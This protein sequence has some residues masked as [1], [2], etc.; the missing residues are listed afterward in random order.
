MSD[1]IIENDILKATFDRKNGAL[2]GLLSKLSG[3]SIHRRRELGLS[4][5]MLVPLEERRNN[6]IL[7]LKQRAPAVEVDCGGN[8]IVFVWEKLQSEYG[9]QL[10]ITFKGV[11][12]ICDDGLVFTPEILN[13]SDR[14]VEVVS[15]PVVGDVTIPQQ[16]QHLHRKGL[17][18]GQMV[19]AEL[20]PRFEDNC[21]YWG[22]DYPTQQVFTPETP[23]VL[24]DSEKQGL[25]VGY[26]DTTAKCL[27]RYAFLLRPGYGQSDGLSIGTVPQGD[28]IGAEPVC[29]EFAA[30]HL[31]YIAGGDSVEL[32]PI[33]L[34][35]Y[36]GSWEAGADCY[37]KWRKTWF[38]PPQKPA[39]TQEV[40]SWQQIHIN[41]PED[42][43]RCRYKN[44]VQYGRDCA[45]HGVGAIQLTGWTKDGQD[46]GNPSHDVEPRLGSREE[47]RDAI[48]AIEEMGVKVVLFNKYTWA[49]R[50]REQ[51]RA[52]LHRHATIDPYGDMHVFVGYHYQTSTQLS[53]INT[54]RFSV[55]CQC[56]AEWRK[57]AV[58]E[59]K[60][61]I[62]LGASGMLY[63]ECQHHGGVRYCFSS[64]HGHTVPAYLFSGDAD[65]AKEFRRVA[66]ELN[67][68]YLF[69]G[70]ACYDLE[71]EHYC[72]SY[73]RIDSRH[74]P[75][76][77]YVAPQAE[78]MI[79][80]TGY[81]NRNTINQALLYRYI[82]SYEPRN[83]KGRLDE[84]PLTLAYG[85]QVD[86]LRRRYATM[87]W[88]AKYRGT[89]GARITPKDSASIKYS[90]F[91]S[92][93]MSKRAVIVANV[94][95]Q[96][97]MNICVEFDGSLTGSL[98]LV[99]PEEPNLR[100]SDGSVML[101]PLS[102]AVIME[103]P[104]E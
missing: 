19:A 49:D 8:R 26:H 94:D 48:E 63:D 66:N 82:L 92:R 98:F 102:A 56:S 20:Y 88:K 46:G 12:T 40:H 80:I 37:K 81:N 38:T 9:G 34:Q 93:Q 50:S 71:L 103:G 87:L 13:R 100:Q 78:M 1:I 14:T 51:F 17:G 30:E 90:V 65:L 99:T 16:A 55:M 45:R 15:W 54:R 11:V 72:L 74:V 96:E 68:E 44:L 52:D 70:E 75:L 89:V 3:W 85:K 29:I 43:L 31:P 77:R 36:V 28:C 21:G 83:F 67:P 95:Q 22:T 5:S 47:L 4:F 84:F 23:F 27:V 2:I 24:I 33:V 76:Y 61:G 18:H 79:A 91:S 41:S 10:D 104:C 60:K 42:E 32:K 6:L 101:P 97:S 59:F 53:D 58:A 62:Q 69:A 39:W 35:P 25:Y 57:V 7:G 86:A 64:Q 73:F